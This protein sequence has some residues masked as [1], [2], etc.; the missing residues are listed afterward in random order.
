MG[1]DFGRYAEALRFALEVHGK[2]TRKGTDIPYITHP[3]AVSAELAR[4]GQAE[5]LVIAGLLHDTI[6]DGGVTRAEIERLFGRRVA[7]LVA[8][9]T[10]EKE[11]GGERVPWRV[12]K[13]QQLAHL[14][15]AD[16]DV[17]T[18][19]AADTL[20]N[21]RSILEDLRLRGDAIWERFRAGREE[22]VW[23]YTSVAKG[24]VDRLGAE[25]LAGELARAAGELAS[26]QD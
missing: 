12:R 9:V 8:G 24:I 22:Q 4:H 11:R 6:E 16:R 5:D 7:E 19:K 20:H 10:E 23:Y 15:V 18:L 13:E 1:Y 14:L 21:I 2:M 25:G 26:A 3:V 17:L